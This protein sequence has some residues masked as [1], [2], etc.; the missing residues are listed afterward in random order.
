[1]AHRGGGHD[2]IVSSFRSRPRAGG[3][4]SGVHR[5]DTPSRMAPGRTTPWSPSHTLSTAVILGPTRLGSERSAWPMPDEP[6][7]TGTIVV[8]GTGRV[9][10][11]PDVADL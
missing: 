9:A 11:E 7:A 4:E 5:H 8:S 2:G 3:E 6:T 1:M 10:V